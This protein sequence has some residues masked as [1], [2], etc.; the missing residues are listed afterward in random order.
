MAK[1]NI[2]VDN[3]IL[4]VLTLFGSENLGFETFFRY[5]VKSLCSENIH[6]VQY[7]LNFI[8]T[9]LAKTTVVPTCYNYAS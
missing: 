9:I 1:W 2:E 4:S 6:F 7:T 8:E 5:F 3:R